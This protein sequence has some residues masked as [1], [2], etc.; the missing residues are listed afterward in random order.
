MLS[1]GATK[2]LPGAPSALVPES[3][4]D[5]LAQR[6]VAQIESGQLHPG[7]R[8]PTEAQLS[9]LHGVSRSVV[10]EAVH[11]VK[12][13]G[14]LVSRQG[15]GVFVAATSSGNNL[16]FNPDAATLAENGQPATGVVSNVISANG[17]NG[18]TLNGADNNEIV[19]NRIGT[20]TDGNTAMANGGH[21]IWLTNGATGV[22]DIL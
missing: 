17:G 21:G 19:S 18:M 16:G 1:T 20:S 15:S 3:L 2:A 13:R 22:L 10:R 8:L 14:L 12:S 7:E 5:R 4:S 6:L 9:Q 11:R